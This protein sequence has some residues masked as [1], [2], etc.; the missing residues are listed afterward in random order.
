MNQLRA[1][2]KGSITSL[3]LLVS[4]AALLRLVD[5]GSEASVVDGIALVDVLG[6]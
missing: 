1:N 2:L 6:A 5:V 4:L 3:G